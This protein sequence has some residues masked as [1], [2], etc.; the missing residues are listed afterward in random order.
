MLNITDVR[1][2]VLGREDSKLCAVA[3]I[4]FDDAFVVHDI[5]V[6]EGTE[7]RFIVM[8]SRK[9]PAG[10]FRDIAHPLNTE[11]REQIKQIVLKKYEEELAN[12]TTK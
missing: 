8:P 2:K 10:E 3:S 4:I 6:I 12:P 7:G 1:V 11:T 5:K 9:T